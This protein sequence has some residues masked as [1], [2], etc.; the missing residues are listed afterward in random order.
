[1]TPIRIATRRSRLALAQSQ[2]IADR[3][4]A[5][6]GRSV[7]LVPVATSGDDTTQPIEV[8][9][10]TGVFVAAVREAVLSG[11]ADVAVHSMKDLPTTAHPGLRLA[12]SPVRE[13]ARDAVCA[14]D[15]RTLADLAAGARVAT[16]S[17]RRIAQLR[18]V[19]SDLDYVPMR[20]NV[21]TRLARVA[22]G[23]VDAVVLAVAGLRRLGRADAATDLLPIEVCTPAPAQGALAVEC[24]DDLRDTELLDA[25]D[26]LD[27]AD[28][29]TVVTAER[30]LLAALQAGCTAPVGAFGLV[31]GTEITLTAVVADI[32]GSTVIRLSDT[33]PAAAA[34]L[35]G[36]A[37]AARL[38]TAGATG[39]LGEP[40]P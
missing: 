24:R 30:R 18:A 5:Q 12:A 6:T 26:R 1:M 3:I 20:G 9:G 16:G 15:G 14:R 8:M 33:G 37:L 19:R 13:D 4:A 38:L 35:R 21:D 22:A 17:P 29:R 34:E 28:T 7:T 25:L 27:D 36:D 11:R 23:D 31:H 2:R 32:S 10:T 40:I 39:L